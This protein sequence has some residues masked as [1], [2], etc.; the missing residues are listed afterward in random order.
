MFPQSQIPHLRADLSLMLYTL[1][2]SHLPLISPAHGQCQH[3]TQVPFDFRSSRSSFHQSL[4]L[5]T[6]LP[7]SY[8]PPR[9]LGY[10]VLS[11]INQI[12]VHDD[13]DKE[14]ARARV[15]Q[16]KRQDAS[17][18]LSKS[19]GVQTCSVHKSETHDH[20]K[21]DRRETRGSRRVCMRYH[22]DH[23]DHITAIQGIQIHPLRIYKTLPIEKDP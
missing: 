7:C 17:R 4:R 20:P 6:S 12:T 13:Q 9:F 1:A 21:R 22:P 23:T 18:K 15:K 2:A 10:C 19:K 3:V 8:R 14:D 11:R 16:N 5:A